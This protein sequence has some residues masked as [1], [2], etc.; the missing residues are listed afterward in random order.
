MRRLAF[1]A[2]LAAGSAFV[3]ACR[4]GEADQASAPRAEASTPG[5]T[6]SVDPHKDGFE[7]ALGEWT[8]TPEAEAI[9]PGRSTFVISTSR[10]TIATS[11][12]STRG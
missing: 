9:R 2:L 7:V 3:A 11:A 10:V 12:R 5:E 1:A 6:T 8:I 4:G